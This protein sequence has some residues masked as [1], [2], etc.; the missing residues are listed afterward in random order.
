MGIAPKAIIGMLCLAVGISLLAPATAGASPEPLS[1][2][3]PLS[4]PQVRPL[5]F[6]NIA[7]VTVAPGGK[8]AVNSPAVPATARSTTVTVD[9]DSGED[10]VGG[11]AVEL[12]RM[13]KP[14]GGADRR[15]QL[16]FCSSIVHFAV[17][18]IAESDDG[19]L[20]L[21]FFAIARACFQ[22]LVQI[23]EPRTTRTSGC[24]PMTSVKAPV[25]VTHTSAGYSVKLAGPVRNA[26]PKFTARCTIN[27]DRLSLRLKA[28]KGKTLASTV[29][30]TINLG[31]AAAPT[32]SA[33]AP[34]TVTFNKP[35]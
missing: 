6:P 18:Q 28:K 20:N 31:F 11:F 15:Q 10:W 17:G 14:K 23:L 7:K 16:L 1:A 24:G 29:G 3:R 19:G 30:P 25:I 35:R 9:K 27:G 21:L 13:T 32:N 12:S 5:F 8:A 26:R 34:M 2:S 33:A 22:A 4:S